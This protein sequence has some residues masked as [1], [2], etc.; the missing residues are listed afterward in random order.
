MEERSNAPVSPRIPTEDLLEELRRLADEL[1]ETPTVTQVEDQGNYSSSSYQRRFDS[2]KDA[3][4]AAGLTP[5]R[6]EKV[7]RDELEEEM[8]RVA[9]EVGHA[10]TKKEMNEIGRISERTYL[11]EY[12][13]WLTA[14]KAAGLSGKLQQPNKRTPKEELLDALLDLAEE[15]GR[16]PKARDM[17]EQGEHTHFTYQRRFG[18]WNDALRE[19]DLE[20][21]FDPDT[22]EFEPYYGEN[23]RE[24]REKALERDNYECRV[25]GLTN[26]QHQAAHD[27]S[28]HVHHIQPLRTFDEPEDANDVENLVVLCQGCHNR[29]EGIPLEPQRLGGEDGE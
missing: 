16:T 7:S 6:Y 28:L 9:D 3:V 25:C 21:V 19:A 24:Q 4:Q 12:D 11:R 27:Q 23:W 26:E 8:R 17:T 13:D 20:L 22:A 1:G 5:N 2:Y 14:R 18:S 15:L 10:P 29:W